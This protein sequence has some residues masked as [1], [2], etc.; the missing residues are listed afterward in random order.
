MASIPISNFA[1]GVGASSSTYFRGDSPAGAWVAP[2]GLLTVDSLGAVGNGTTDDTAA[3]AAIAAALPEGGTIYLSPGKFYY[4][5]SSWTLPAGVTLKGP[6]GSF[7]QQVVSGFGTAFG[8][9]LLGSSATITMSSGSCIDGCLI[10][11]HGMTFPQGGSSWSGT[12]ITIS[13]GSDQTVK[14]S[15]IAG[16]SQGIS[17]SNANRCNFLHLQMDNVNGISITSSEDTA[18]IESVHCWPFL[19]VT[20]GTNLTRSGTAFSINSSDDWAMFRNCFAYGYNTYGFYNNASAAVT[21]DGCGTDTCGIGFFINGAAVDCGLV[22]C[23]AGGCTNGA[24][25]Q[26]TG[27][28]GSVYFDGFMS[29]SN[30]NGI[31]ATNTNTVP[32]SIVGGSH[33]GNTVW[34]VNIASS[35]KTVINGAIFLQIGSGGAAGTAGTGEIVGCVLS[36]GATTGFT[37]TASI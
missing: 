26:V 18:R 29:W 3:F 32:I 36:S 28:T 20:T 30:T 1:G 11:V 33:R 31:A 25:V 16:F 8:N 21:F 17:A 12:A 34:G 22:G 4:T 10:L 27:G 7:G 5:A 37:V 19:T 35:T 2:P 9:I 6:Y 13:A 24:I 14:N 23:Q 15:M